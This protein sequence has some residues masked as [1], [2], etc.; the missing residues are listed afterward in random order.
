LSGRI[1]LWTALIPHW[2]EHPWLGYGYQT[3]WSSE[4]IGNLSQSV[5]WTVSNGHSALLD[6]LLDLGL[7]GGALY[8]IGVITG[9][10]HV[11]RQYFASR[12]AGC[13]FLL[14]LFAG[15]AAIGML[16]SAFLTPTNFVSF[17]LVCGLVHVAFYQ[18]SHIAGPRANSSEV[19]RWHPL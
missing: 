2:L 13:A 15:R 9:L 14:L 18:P 3:F 4:R 10:R 5:Q 16:E 17:I 7:I 19:L 11:S 12:D 1:P 6:T 8:L